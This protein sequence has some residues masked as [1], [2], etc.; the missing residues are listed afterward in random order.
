MLRLLSLFSGIGA[1]EKALQREGIDYELVNYC[2]I[3]PY[4]SRTYSKLYSVSEDKNLIDVTKIDIDSLPDFYLLTHSFPCTSISI[5]GKLEGADRGSGAASSL[6]WNVVDIIEV[7]RPKVVIFENVKN[8]LSKKF[9]HVLNAYVEHLYKLGYRTSYKVLTATDF[10]IPQSRERVFCV[11]TL[12]GKFEFGKVSYNKEK[13]L[14]KDILEPV[15]D[16]KYYLSKEQLMKIYNWKAHQR[17]LAK[18]RGLNSISPTLTARGAGEWHSGM[19]L[20]CS[21]F[22]KDTNVDKLIKLGALRGKHNNEDKIYQNLELRKDGNTNTITTVQKDNLVCDL[23]TIRRLTPKES[24]RLMGFDDE[25][26][27]KAN[28]L[29]F[30]DAKLYKMAGNSVVVPVLEEIFR[31]MK[32]Q[33][34]I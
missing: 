14:L 10:G 2:E 22:E 26:F 28:E 4:P 23:T 5:A 29:G 17:P 33:N 20:Y 21:Q 8:L 30:S 31:Q 16:D 7:K 19:M 15:V 34:F 27:Y 6:V 13:R 12:E 3:D 18:V 32:A 25:D 9:E 24:W 11:S 1:Y